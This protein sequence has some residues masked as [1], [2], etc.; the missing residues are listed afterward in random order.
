MHDASIIPSAHFPYW[1]KHFQRHA[2]KL[3]DRWR[4]WRREGFEA[5]FERVLA[6]V[7]ENGPVRS[8]DL[9]APDG[10]GDGWWDW[11]PSKTALE[12]LWR[13][14]RLAVT[15]REGFQKFYDLIDRV[16][17][18]DNLTRP[19]TDDEL[20]DWACR[21]ALHHLGFATHGE[22][23]AFWALISPSE[24]QTWCVSTG[25]PEIAVADAAGLTRRAY[26][27]PGLLDTAPPEPSGGV[28]VLS[29]FDPMIRDRKRTER[30]FG[31][32]Y[33]IEVFVPEARRKYGY[34]VFPLL[35]RDRLIGR[36]DM[37]ADRASGHLRVRALWLEAGVGLGKGRIR[38]IE[39]E[40][41]RLCRFTRL[42]N[43]ASFAGDWKRT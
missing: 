7:A 1:Q 15:R 42:E 22:L 10:K 27:A 29:P 12:F 17:A 32:S 16:L 20:V 31:F 13:T 9:G 4:S 19:V 26:A 43:G 24:A 8:R 34:Y 6:H 23:A 40:L 5:E 25:L 36:I 14:G 33:R 39:T 37:K 41:D 3:R 30:L 18:G 21:S 28:R 11:H 2:E 35:E 38:R